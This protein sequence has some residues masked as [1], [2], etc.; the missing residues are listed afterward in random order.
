MTS[1]YSDR[2]TWN[3]LMKACKENDL[4]TVRRVL[5]DLN[6]NK[7]VSQISALLN[8]VG[9][10]GEFLLFEAAGGP[11]PNLEIVKFATVVEE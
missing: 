3:T 2:G 5:V 8:L 10:E 1:G 11:S 4:S 6:R 7:T 9:N